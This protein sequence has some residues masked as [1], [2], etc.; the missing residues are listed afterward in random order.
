VR[1]KAI[2]EQETFFASFVDKIQL[3]IAEVT[4]ATM[5]EARGARA[6]AASEIVFF[7][8]GG[9]KASQSCIPGYPYSS[10][11]STYN[12]DVKLFPVQTFKVFLPFPER[13]LHGL[14]PGKFFLPNDYMLSIA[15]AQNNWPGT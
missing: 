12:Q 8:E 9:F 1:G 5:D 13:E 14:T 10:Y 4:E 3:K 15:E 6:G 11:S 2:E 7:K